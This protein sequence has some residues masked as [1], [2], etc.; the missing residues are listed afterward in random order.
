M[1][2]GEASFRFEPATPERWDDLQA[3]FGE[4]GACGGCWCMV[5]R[6][7]RAEFLKGKGP[8]N[9]AS[10]RALVKHGPPP[11]VLAYDGDQAVGWC[12]VA[13]RPDYVFLSKSRVLRPVDETPVWPVSC[14][15]V[16]K[17]YRRKG[18]SVALL[19]AAVEFVRN[20]GGAMVE[21]YPIIS[22]KGPLPDSFAWTGT[23]PAFLKAGFHELPRWSENRPIVRI[24]VG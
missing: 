14:L 13:P 11:G 7:P 23:L 8:G 21:G 5:W 3:L 4:R 15:F 12:A 22:K 16:A 17:P 20:R 2:T 6:K 1:S 19:R 9:R 24:A 18:L 10:L